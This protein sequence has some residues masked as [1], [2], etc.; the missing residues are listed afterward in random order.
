MRVCFDPNLEPI[1]RVIGRAADDAGAHAWVVGGVVRDA[2]IGAQVADIDIT[3][4]GNAESVVRRLD[5]EW[6]AEVEH[7]DAFSTATL[8]AAGFPR[9]DMVR[10]RKETYSRPG[11]LPDVVPSGIDDD[12]ARRDF[13]VNAI[14][15]DLG[16]EHFGEVLDPFSGQADLERR[17]LRILH[18]GSFIDDPTRL[19]RAARYGVRLGLK[20]DAATDEAASLAVCGGA[21]ETISA[22]R[23]R[24]E[25]ELIITEPRWVDAVVWLNRWGVWESLAGGWT[26]VASTLKRADVVRAWALRTDKVSTPPAADLRWLTFLAAAPSPIGDALAVKPVELRLI[27]GVQ[28]VL[29]SLLE[30]DGPA[31]W[32]EMDGEPLCA[33]LAATA[34]SGSDSQKARL[35]RYI[36]SVRNVRLSISGDDLLLSGAVPGPALGLALNLTLDGVRTGRLTGAEAELEYAMNAWRE[37]I[38]A[39][40]NA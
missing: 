10:A 40:D 11:A 32:R 23:R 27:A 7:H 30:A 17:T 21:L 5:D 9:V 16:E 33:L 14:A 24:R 39:E 3:I 31:W 6:K 34:L 4:V 35:T 19:F 12:L 1:L 38:G 2:L 18:A 20:P 13:S 37:S 8:V 36:A 26:P 28:A 15:V 22:D 29:A 25:V